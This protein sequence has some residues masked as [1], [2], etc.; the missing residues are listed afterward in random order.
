MK[1]ASSP[2]AAQIPREE[3]SGF[4]RAAQ[5]PRKRL[6]FSVL[7]NSSQLS[8]LSSQKTQERTVLRW[9]KFNLVGLI[10]IGVQLAALAVFRSLLQL[11]Y[12]LAT[13][14]AVE[15]AVLHNFLWHQRYTWA[16]RGT[17]GPG[18]SLLRLAKFNAS[19]GA[20]S[21][22]ANIGLMRVLVGEFGVNYVVA[23]LMA[24]TVCSILNFLLSDR[25]VFER[26]SEAGNPIGVPR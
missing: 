15:T 18:Q 20:V 12:L 5:T 24:I 6:K 25:F 8:V 16:D 21:I 22:L 26:E 3:R 11:N 2:N 9:L 19:N 7:K 23:N 10:G 17:A 13:A 14:L 1:D 4:R